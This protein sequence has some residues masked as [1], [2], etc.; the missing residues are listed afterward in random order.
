MNETLSVTL[1]AF[2]NMSSNLNGIVKYVN[3]LAQSFE[4]LQGQIKSS[5]ETVDQFGGSLKQMSTGAGSASSSMDKTAQSVENTGQK[6]ATTSE[7]FEALSSKL[8]VSS[9]HA[10]IFDSGI[11]RIIKRVGGIMLVGKAFSLVG[12]GISKALGRLD[13]FEVFRRN[14]TNFVGDAQ[15]AEDA[16]NSLNDYSTGTAYALDTASI[17]AQR[18]VT[19]GGKSIEESVEMT[20]GWMDII[21]T[22]GKGTSLEL[23]S[24]ANALTKML[25]KGK[26]NMLQT[27]TLTQTIGIPVV[28]AYAAAVGQSS[29]EVQDALSAGEITAEEFEKTVREALLNGVDGFA[30]AS[31]MAKLAGTTWEATLANAQ[32]AVARGIQS[33]V[34]SVNKGFENTSGFDFKSTYLNFFKTFEI[35]LKD[36]GKL[37]ES[38]IPKV[39]EFL[40]PLVDMINTEE[41]RESLAHTIEKLIKSLL[42][43]GTLT[44][45][46][47]ILSTFTDKLY[48]LGIYG[49]MA[50]VGI[51]SAFSGANELGKV[52]PA[53]SGALGTTSENI[54]GKGI[55]QQTTGNAVI[56]TIQQM[57]FG[58]SGLLRSADNVFNFVK[59]KGAGGFKAITTEASNAAE[60]LKAIFTKMGNYSSVTGEKSTNAWAKSKDSIGSTFMLMSSNAQKSFANI[61]ASSEVGSAQTTNPWVKGVENLKQVFLGFIDIPKS[62]ALLLKEAFGNLEGLGV[63][64]EPIKAFLNPVVQFST[65]LFNIGES[66]LVAVGTVGL[67]TA[68]IGALTTGLG[69][70]NADGELG[71][72]ITG[73]FSG[74]NS[75]VLGIGEKVTGAVSSFGNKLTSP[76]VDQQGNVDEGYANYAQLYAQRG[77]ELM[78]AFVNGILSSAGTIVVTF[79]QILLTTLETVI[80]LLPS[81]V[82]AGFMLIQNIITG[83][84][85]EAPKILENVLTWVI[86]TVSDLNERLPVWFELGCEF[87]KNTVKGIGDT[88][89]LL[90]QSIPKLVAGIALL[91]KEKAPEL[92]T[93]GAL[94]IWNLIKGIGNMIGAVINA[95]TDLIFSFLSALTSDPVGFFETCKEIVSNLIEGILNCIKALFDIAFNIGKEFLQWIWNGIVGWW[96][97]LVNNWN[98]LWNQWFGEGGQADSTVEIKADTHEV[99]TKLSEA[100]EQINL[101][102]QSVEGSPWRIMTEVTGTEAMASQTQDTADLISN[103]TDIDVDT[104]LG[105]TNGMETQLSETLGGIEDNNKLTVGTNLDIAGVVDSTNQSLQT[106]TDQVQSKYDELVNGA[107]ST[108]ERIRDNTNNTFISTFENTQNQLNTVLEDY[109]MAMSIKVN[110]T[111][112]QLRQVIK[113]TFGDIRVAFTESMEGIVHDTSINLDQINAEAAKKLNDFK[114]YILDNLATIKE[115]YKNSFN[116][117]NLIT[118]DRLISASLIA[119][120]EM[121]NLNREMTEKLQTLSTDIQNTFSLMVEA[122]TTKYTDLKDNLV[123]E[124]SE[125]IKGMNRKLVTGLSIMEEN[126]DVFSKHI[127][128][129][130]D[131]LSKYHKSA[132]EQFMTDLK[133][134]IDDKK[135]QVLDATSDLVSKMKEV[136]IKQLGIHSPSRWGYYV[137]QMTGI[138]VLNGLSETELA[139]FVESV[140]NNMKSSFENG[141]FNANELVA[142]L[143][144]DTLALIG[145]LTGVDMSDVQNNSGQLVWPIPG[146]ALQVNSPYGD[147]EGRSHVH[148]GIDLASGHGNPIVAALPGT[149]NVAGWYYGYGNAVQ[150]DHGNGIETLYGHFLGTAVNVGD[151]VAAGQTIGFS[152]STGNSTGDH[153]HFEVLINGQTTD[154]LPYLQGS[155]VGVIGNPLVAA[156]QTAYYRSKGISLPGWSSGME[157]GINYDPSSGTSQWSSTVSQALAMLGQSQSLLPGILQA[158]EAESGGNPNAINDWDSN[159]EAGIPSKG[160]MQVIDPTF[161]RYALPGFDTNIYD[162]MSNILAALNYMINVYGSISNVIEP[163]A[164]GWYGYRVGTRYVPQDM[165]AIIHQGEAILPRSQNPYSESGGNYLRDIG[166]QVIE[167]ARF[168]NPPTVYES[169]GDIIGS[170]FGTEPQVSFG[171]EVDL[172]DIDQ[173]VPINVPI[174]STNN[175]NSNV[176]DQSTQNITF[177]VTN[178][179]QVDADSFISSLEQEMHRLLVTGRQRRGGRV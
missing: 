154:P 131:G 164:G 65:G 121:N 51:K 73:F 114:T 166:K 150:I 5:E 104:I 137:G 89:I 48:N 178:N 111:V 19:S 101:Q 102:K 52:K 58:L 29:Q 156:I 108:L 122:V 145:Y 133:Q 66:A 128:E 27:N 56:E 165:P 168:T 81:F 20:K 60:G 163:R 127:R 12:N 49:R 34:D 152:D 18:M 61:S 21:S 142:Y 98:N 139:S 109:D 140:I 80:T 106:I 151:T 160:L 59:S 87:I 95:A 68:A 153:L 14:V 69:M 54:T 38:T 75:S 99:E 96:T 112:D 179:K 32:N 25:S 13:T 22:Y 138:G 64:L 41:G 28:R 97:N 15:K 144:D 90:F 149:V 2:D 123:S 107:N 45:S 119:Q 6:V 76:V 77:I 135:Q 82:N 36:F 11:G 4:R 147:T 157:G 55:N 71:I 103:T 83:I 158:I 72:K 37:V 67:L 70:L 116:E 130:L 126:Y 146:Y 50:Y 169:F 9:K 3:E 16:I 91:F 120:T 176:S 79:V 33:I 155:S 148:S 93:Q 136:F 143:G 118:I 8:R 24:A 47:T 113:T 159:W 161:Q 17:M 78:G 173:S 167:G 35:V 171:D 7:Q 85:T 92:I 26:V 129:K 74:L 84:T 30:A 10:G 125:M 1:Q 170:S 39:V 40:R 175:N 141:K 115:E 172:T 43:F 31:G 46:S 134:G 63:S 57:S 100:K 105:D 162:P 86:Q 177:N 94:L 44:T 117:I 174:P 42:L 132:G 124:T 53:V 23:E 62:I 110:S 88:A